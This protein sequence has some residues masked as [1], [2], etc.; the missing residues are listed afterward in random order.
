MFDQLCGCGKMRRH[1]L[2]GAGWGAE[3]LGHESHGP[4]GHGVRVT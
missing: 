2:Y 3:C 4:A 1:Y